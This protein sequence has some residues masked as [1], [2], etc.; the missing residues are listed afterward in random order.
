MLGNN[1]RS[2]PRDTDPERESGPVDAVGKLCQ[3]ATG[4]RSKVTQTVPGRTR[5]ARCKASST[6]VSTE[7]SPWLGNGCVWVCVCVHVC[8]VFCVPQCWCIYNTCMY[9]MSSIL[10]CRGN[11][12]SGCTSSGAIRGALAP[13]FTKTS[14]CLSKF[15]N[16]SYTAVILSSVFNVR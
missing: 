14:P 1:G 5:S 16:S 8:C 12:R 2:V 7:S 10:G 6:A 4:R 15:N 13:S 9:V 11:T 3:R